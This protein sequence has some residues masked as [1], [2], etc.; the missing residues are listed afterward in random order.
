MTTFAR[1]RAEEK[2]AAIAGRP[3]YGRRLDRD[4]RVT[5]AEEFTRAERR[6]N[7][8]GGHMARSLDLLVPKVLKPILGSWAGSHASTLSALRSP[9]SAESAT[10]IFTGIVGPEL[11]AHSRISARKK[12]RGKKTLFVAVDHPGYIA[13]LSPFNSALKEAFRVEEVRIG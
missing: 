1:Q 4:E 11:A 8:G 10:T 5:L 3:N 13:Y 2:L 12:W 7:F 6:R 9:L